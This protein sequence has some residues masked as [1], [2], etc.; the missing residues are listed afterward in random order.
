[1]E[2]LLQIRYRGLEPSDALSRLIRKEAEKLAGF[3][4]RIV[5]CRV[6]VEREER[7]IRSGAP[8]RVHIELTIPGDELT[9]DTAVAKDVALTVRNAFRRARRRLQSR[10]TRMRGPHV[11]SSVR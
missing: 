11:R 2:S 8:N 1:M 10:V 4:D 7:H 5:S 6:L 9:I 3:F